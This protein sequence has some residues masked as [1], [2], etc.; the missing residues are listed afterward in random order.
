M[1][2]FFQGSGVEKPVHFHTLDLSSKDLCDAHPKLLIF[3]LL[4][5]EIILLFRLPIHD[6]P[7]TGRVQGSLI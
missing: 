3:I 5:N 7:L 2:L 4:K 1:C 6:A